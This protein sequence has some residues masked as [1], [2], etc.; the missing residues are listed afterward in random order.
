[1]SIDNRMVTDGGVCVDLFIGGENVATSL[2]DDGV[3]VSDRRT[4]Q[5]EVIKTAKKPA[6]GGKVL[7][8]QPLGYLVGS[9]SRAKH[10]HRGRGLPDRYV[11]WQPLDRERLTRG[12][13]PA[14]FRNCGAWP[15]WFVPSI[16]P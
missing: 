4:G 3:E 7:A 5:S 2:T 15:R 11:D 10:A 9:S 16:Q 13:P 12:R 6:P 14:Q 8:R 1:M